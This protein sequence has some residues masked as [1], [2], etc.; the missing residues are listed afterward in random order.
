MLIAKRVEYYYTLLMKL[1]ELASKRASSVDSIDTRASIPHSRVSGGISGVRTTIA[2]SLLALIHFFGGHEPNRST[3]LDRDNPHREV[4]LD[5]DV[6]GTRDAIIA[7][8]GP[9]SALAFDEFS[10]KRV[11]IEEVDLIELNHFYDDQGRLVFSQVIYYDWCN[12]AHR[13][14]VR[15]WRLLKSD[16]QIPLRDWENGGYVSEWADFKQCNGLR[17]IKSGSVRETW[18]QHD[19]ELCEREVLAQEKRKELKR[20]PNTQSQHSF[21][22]P[23]PI[24]QE[25]IPNH[26]P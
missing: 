3:D 13:Y 15:D 20:I 19:P 25:R 1:S 8:L 14:Q 17:R 16:T 11:T 26:T 7:L 21:S 4:A 18:T 5:H 12:Q 2:L 10:K 6:R 24:R 23:R 22:I 9:N